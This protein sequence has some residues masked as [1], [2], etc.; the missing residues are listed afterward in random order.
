[1]TVL[2]DVAALADD[3]SWNYQARLIVCGAYQPWDLGAVGWA[4]GSVHHRSNRRYRD[5]RLF[6]AIGFSPHTLSR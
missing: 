5:Y 6:H 2:P 4:G 1:V 3:Q